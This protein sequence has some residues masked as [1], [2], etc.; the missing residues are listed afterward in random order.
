MPPMI[1]SA[2]IARTATTGMSKRLP[3]RRASCITLAVVKAVRSACACHTG[4]SRQGAGE[5][6]GGGRRGKGRRGASL[7]PPATK[8]L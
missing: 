7:Q 5:V 2:A 3:L 8:A 4:T 1:W 6:G